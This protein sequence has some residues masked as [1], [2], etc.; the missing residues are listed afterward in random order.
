MNETIIAWATHTFNVVHGCSKP[1]AVPEAGFHI[2]RERL[3]TLLDEDPRDPVPAL[4]MARHIPTSAMTEKWSKPDTSPECARCYAENLSN[5]RGQFNIRNG[6]EAGAWTTEPWTEANAEKNVHLHP[7]RIRQI[8]TLEVKP[9]DLPP[10]QRNRV[11]IC[12]MGDIFHDLVPDEFIQE[13]FYQ[14]RSYP[15]IYMLLTKRPDRAAKLK[16]TWPDWVWLG[17]TCGHP[18]TKWR[19]EYLRQSPAKVRFVSMEPLL[20]SMVGPTADQF[21]G[22]LNLAGID[23]VIVGGESGTGFRRM[24]KQWAREVRDICAAQDTAFFYKQDSAFQTEVRPW[25]IEPDGRRLQYRQFPGEMTAPGHPGG[26]PCLIPPPCPCP[27]PGSLNW[28]STA[29]ARSS[30]A[31]RW[32]STRARSRRFPSGRNLKN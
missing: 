26:E 25:L 7:E 10:S 4:K 28:K 24:D 30:E 15:N 27:R 8:R 1:P 16:V 12:S 13:L 22:P 23:Q 21:L 3:G 17:A 11:F 19:L 29:C 14:M 18:V 31:H 2:F 6:K 9:M 5:R 20:A 32:P